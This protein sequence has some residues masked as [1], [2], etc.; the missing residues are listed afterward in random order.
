MEYLAKIGIMLWN[1]LVFLFEEGWIILMV[2]KLHFILAV[3]LVTLL[4]SIFAVFSTFLCNQANLPNLLGKWLEYNQERANKRLG[5]N[6]KKGALVMTALTTAIV[7]SPTTSAVLLDISGV[8]GK[9][10][11]AC[12]V[13]LSFLSS[14]T[15]CVLYGGGLLILKGVLKWTI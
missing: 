3:F 6:Y 2:V 4:L 5:S 10:A 14:T 7:I 1:V 9:K 8:K 12:D 13:I 15:W 11:Y